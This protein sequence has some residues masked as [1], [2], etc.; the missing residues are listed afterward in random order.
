M[1]DTAKSG[2]ATEPPP[3]LPYR[4]AAEQQLRKWLGLRPEDIMN[5][6]TEVAPVRDTPTHL[7]SAVTRV[8]TKEQQQHA[9]VCLLLPLPAQAKDATSTT[10]SSNGSSN[11]A[12][13]GHEEGQE[14]WLPSLGLDQ[15][16]WEQVLLVLKILQVQNPPLLQNLMSLPPLLHQD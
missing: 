9:F 1:E 3:N 16:Q 15:Q 2:P 10:R 14:V 8:T 13:A 5:V 12:S 11:G 6:V 4:L 7:Y